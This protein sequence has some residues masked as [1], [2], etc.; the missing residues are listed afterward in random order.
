MSKVVIGAVLLCLCSGCC[1]PEVVYR[2]AYQDVLIPVRCE[3]AA[4]VKPAKADNAALQIIDLIN[5]THELE[6]TV[7]ACGGE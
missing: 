5:Y 6:L 7:R 3:I 1:K 4:P 2:T